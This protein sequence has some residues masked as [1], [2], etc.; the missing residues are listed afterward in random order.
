MR[1]ALILGLAFVAALFGPGVAGAPSDDVRVLVFTKTTEFRHDSIPAALTALRGLGSRGGFTVNATE[2]ATSFSDANLA[3]YDVVAFILTTGD[4]LDDDQQAAFE[5]YIRHGGG[6][7]GVHSAADT[8]HDWPWYGR[9]VGA[10]FKVHPS[11][12]SAVVDVVDRSQPSTLRLPQRWSRRDEWYNYASNPRGTVRVLA[13]LDETTYAPGEGA[14][15]SDHPIAWSQQF[16]GGRAW[17]TGGGH[18]SESYSEP[19]FLGHVLGGILWAAGIDPP[20]IVSVTVAS[21]GSRMQV[22]ARHSRCPRC[23]VHLRIRVH[24]SRSSVLMR[25]DGTTARASTRALP[26]GRWQLVFVIE[27]RA[28]GSATTFTHRLRVRSKSA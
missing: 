8:E 15:G 11:I 14:M 18:T 17:Y 3:R 16:Q 26:P 4:V 27:D 6:F 24:G 10:Y 19:R 28:T 25:T 2:D 22:T 13:T 1:T 5:R 7:V 20:R 23:T 12:Q 21:R 9:L